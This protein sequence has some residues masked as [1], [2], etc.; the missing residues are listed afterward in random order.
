MQTISPHQNQ[1][2]ARAGAPPEEAESAMI[3]IHGRGATAEGILDLARVLPK[4]GM[5]YF[6]P[7]AANGGWYPYRFIAPVEENEP[8]LSSA[9]S[10]VD[11][12]VK[13]LNAS[14]IP[15][16]HIVL[17]GFSQG[18]CLA[19]EYA[20]RNPAKYAGVLVFSGGLIGAQLPPYEGT[21]ENTPVLLACS[22]I[23]PHIPLERVNETADVF[24]KLGAN[25]SK[26][27]YPGMGHTI[28]AEEIRE[29]QRILLF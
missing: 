5:A 13:D 21:L 20:A 6:A 27:I 23:D 9:L 17:C 12:L 19:S 24:K 1:P 25:V 4:A 15:N 29:A 26:K 3:L 18:A 8:F 2:L 11:D 10:V 22:D 28:N 7:Q 16:T 14:G